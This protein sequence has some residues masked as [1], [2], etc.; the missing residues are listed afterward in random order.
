MNEKEILDLTAEEL[1]SQVR[2][3]NERY[4]QQ[5]AAEISDALYDLLV[6][7]LR[8]LRPNAPVL[9][10]LG[11]DPSAAPESVKVTHEHPMLSL[12]KCY[13]EQ[14][15]LKWFSRF[16]GS[17]V[18]TH[19]VDGVAMSVRY[20]SSG[21][22]ELAATRGNGRVGERITDSA[23]YVRDVPHTVPFGPIEVRGE[24]YMPL[25][26]FNDRFAAE[27]AN[28]RNLTA[29]GLKQ[30]DPR[31][32]A[33]YGI[34]FFAYDVIGLEAATEV[35]KREWLANAGFVPAPTGVIATSED[36]QA[37]FEAIAAERDSI[38][39]EVDGAVF[40]V[41]DVT[42]H[43]GLGLTSHHPRYSIAYKYQ[44]ESG[45]THLESVEWSVSRTGSINPVALVSAVSLSGVSVTRASLHNLGIM[46][47][48]ASR[49]LEIGD[50]DAYPLSNGAGVLITRRGGVIP[51]IERIA[52]PS[53]A[54]LHVPTSCPSCGAATR[55]RDDFLDA[56]HDPTC[57]T[58]AVRQLKHFVS[59]ADL[60]GIGPKLLEQLFD[61]EFVRQPHQLFEITLGDLMSLDRV[62]KRSAENVLAAIRTGRT[63]PLD[64]FL[65]ALGITDLGRSVSRSVAAHFL[66]LDALR[67]VAP[68]TL[69]EVDGVGEV[70]AGS[71]CSGLTRLSDE[72]DA[73]LL[74][75]TVLDAAPPAEATGLLAGRAFVFTGKMQTMG[76]SAA[77]TA[78]S[79]LGAETPSSVTST[80]T[81]VVLGNEDFARYEGGWRSSKLKKA[82]KL[83]ASGAALRIIS[84]DEFRSIIGVD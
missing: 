14:D 18:L 31:K 79:E 37:A 27:Y 15:L 68:E 50:N 6:I 61:A 5:N 8:E 41:N 23:K 64:T 32:T 58:Q 78:A 7:R 75:V 84:E 33:G 30:K 4:W 76:R 81:D 48:L 42:Q 3:H 49:P 83:M 66:S 28:P 17:A 62:G 29:G 11:E 43:D 45:I 46:E 47:A 82:E 24:A 39:F 13:S 26:V 73:L 71:I 53:T 70:M 36:G 44:G 52:T 55:R 56:D 69:I 9:L 63:M 74:H 21:R 2:H 40:K 57:A 67:A 12:D 59:A 77:Q 80:T 60:D 20:D 22:L 54:T 10:E 1:E 38:N 51:H 25:D 16:E 72:I 35:K 34:A 19:K 65:R